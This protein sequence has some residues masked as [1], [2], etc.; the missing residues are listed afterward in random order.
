[1]IRE[2]RRILYP[3]ACLLALSA[4]SVVLAQTVSL[5][6][7]KASTSTG[8]G[9]IT[10][11]A[12]PA[13][14]TGAINLCSTSCTAY[15][16]SNDTVT[17][18]AT[19]D[20]NSTF[21]NWGGDCSGSASGSVLLDA[22]S[23]TCTATFTA[24]SSSVF[25]VTIAK[26]GTGTGTVSETGGKIN[27]GTTCSS[28]YNS[29]SV[30][31]FTASPDANSTFAGWGQNCSTAAT[32]STASL[33]VDAAKTCSAT[34]NTAIQRLTVT[35]TG[36]GSGTVVSS[37][38]G[39]NC[40]SVCT[41]DYASSTTVNLTAT[42]D[43]GM[44]FTG[45][46][47]ACS[48]TAATTKIVLQNPLTCTAN[49]NI[50]PTPPP[51]A[52]LFNITKSGTGKGTVTTSPGSIN[53]GDVCSQEY[54]QNS[55]IV[56]S[57]TPDENS[58]FAGWGAQCSGGGSTSTTVLLNT[59]KTCEVKFSAL[60]ANVWRLQVN[61]SGKGKGT[62]TSMDDQINCGNSCAAEYTS[63]LTM[64][65]TATPDAN[66]SFTGWNSE[67]GE[68][69][70]TTTITTGPS[71]KTCTATFGL[72]STLPKLTI[73]KAGQG[74]G[75]VT[76]TD[77][78]LQCG[79]VCEA[80]Y[81]AGQ[82][83]T[84]IASPDASS[85]FTGW[86][87]EC[88]GNTSAG[89]ITLGDA[90]TT[91]TA[92]FAPK[93]LPQL[94]INKAGQGGGTVTS[95]EGQLQC[96][97][98]CA[99]NYMA[100]NTVTLMASPDANSLFAG[101]GPE[102]D[103]SNGTSATTVT[104]GEADTTCTVNFTPKPPC[105]LQI[106][107]W[108][109]TVS[110][111]VEVIGNSRKMDQYVG[112]WGQD[113]GLVNLNGVSF[114]GVNSVEF[115]TQNQQCYNG[116][117]LNYSYSSCFFKTIFTPITEGQKQ[118]ALNFNFD[119]PTT[120][121]PTVPIQAEAVATGLPK[122]EV[123][124]SSHDFGE[125]TA[126]AL[127]YYQYQR[128]TM[129]NTGNINLSV[130]QLDLTGPNASDFQGHQWSWCSYKGA[131][132]PG[133]ECD[134]YLYFV[135]VEEGD[136]Q[137]NLGVTSNAPAVAVALQ[138][139]ATKPKD[140]E[141]TNITLESVKSGPWATQ[142]GGNYWNY[143]GDSDV[144]QRVNNSTGANYP[145]E[146]DVVRIKSGHTVTA[147]PYAI[148]RTL[149]IE[150]G[151]TL[152]SSNSS[153]YYYGNYVSI[154]AIDYLEN[155]GLIRGKPGANESAGATTCQYSWWG[156]NSCGKPGA[157]VYLSAG[158]FKN[159]GEIVSGQGGSG[160]EYGAWGG[161]ISIYG[162]GLTNTGSGL[163]RAGD[164]GDLTGTQPGQS[165]GGGTIGIWGS[166]YLKSD[167]SRG[168]Y[169]GNGGDCNYAAGQTGGNGGNMRLNAMANVNLQGPFTMGKGGKNCATNGRDGGFN[170]DPN[171][172]T[173]S[174]ANTKVEGGDLTIYGGDG[175]TL[176]LSDLEGTVFT[177]TGN[178][179]LAVGEGGAI[180]MRGS[181][182]D[183]LK[184]SGDVYIFSNTVLLDDQVKL[185]DLIEATNIVVGPAKI[186]HDVS[187][188][189]PGG[190]FGEPQT[191]LPLT[192]SLANGSPAEDT[193]TLTVTD[194]A[195]WPLT[196]LPPTTVTLA[197]LDTIDLSL[198]V[199]LPATRGATNLIKVTATSQADP[200]A[201]ASIEVPVIVAE[202]MTFAP[203][204]PVTTGGT[205][206]P[207]SDVVTPT[208]PTT[209]AESSTSSGTIGSATPAT[210]TPSGTGTGT[211]SQ[212]PIIPPVPNNMI[213]E[214]PTEGV[215]EGMCNNRGR[216]ITGAT[217]TPSAK[218]SGGQ[219]A[220]TIANAGFVS[221]VTIQKTAILKGGT[222]SG[223]IINEGTLEDIKFVG[224]SVTGGTLAGNIINAS[225]VGG[226]FIDVN[227]APNASLRGG[228]LQG[229]IQGDETAPALLEN[230]RVL[231]GSQLT[232]VI[233]G[234]GVILEEGVTVNAV[235]PTT[236]EPPT[237][238]ITPVET[239]PKLPKLAKVTALD[240]EG[241]RITTKTHFAGGIAVNEGTKYET[242][243]KV[244]T[245]VDQLDIRGQMTVE[246]TAVNQTADLFVYASYRLT[247][248]DK[249]IYF[250]LDHNGALLSWDFNNANLVAFK[251]AIKLAEIQPITIYQGTLSAAGYVS[252]HFGYRLADG[253]IVL[254]DDAMTVTISE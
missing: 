128:F 72:L 112:V 81:S 25:T 225:K 238:E 184:A 88:G 119:K 104:L 114:T 49:F 252:I 63:G 190:L 39:I 127:N 78:I 226:V 150:A 169:S 171:V 118:A 120:T 4:P 164:G 236:T 151:G 154:T 15:F 42:A 16:T 107:T 69:L 185:S 210:T 30:V 157:G 12:T 194:S 254:N 206:T 146:K 202:Q 46:S 199:T 173:L 230:V 130:N 134:V 100:G 17:L 248:K 220:G 83:V 29:G 10:A 96:G 34:F 198:T 227:F 214:C 253:S 200:T 87:P 160:Q 140:C 53:C 205:T 235:E 158:I 86:G 62:V 67:C 239:L 221:Q 40:G 145:S 203:I 11:G 172:L 193:F 84:L 168:I 85:S 174:G 183:I 123:S 117:W 136:K 246:Q 23:Q 125:T 77:G 189:N 105:Q 139:K 93:P 167:S 178:I 18:I 7:T 98:V 197:A 111:G 58:S 47:G 44:T 71:S 131:L 113:C 68:T 237:A 27:C 240:A 70:P 162:N 177:A 56:V 66:S 180:D 13:P 31:T 250:M 80:N 143:Q 224:A 79:D 50:I 216:V 161:S 241:Q 35:K 218:L 43:S 89:T 129:K 20:A 82:T 142:T 242:N 217:L 91:C 121:A 48:G 76:S 187:L 110:F 14:T 153:A 182:G 141:D 74:D 8:N 244:K 90:D 147:A 115:S 245:Q 19:P 247:Q 122:I 231:A 37:P 228:K 137:A 103:N 138:G 33:T 108:P 2:I 99:A 133:E 223:Y 75:S 94:I 156:N 144:W 186:L 102:C 9:T 51:P 22:A 26:A 64:S 208:T 215:I 201:S 55:L 176:N 249:A 28:N 54:S 21:T 170:T 251:K 59:A 207:D 97:D 101:W 38:S 195:G 45:W 243:Q 41:A 191:E 5:T 175:W 159:A 60:P 126:G 212:V 109:S 73:N 211:T 229:R 57:A 52:T 219:L 209:G 65:L 95:A 181:S 234:Q 124:P 148:V 152:E 204:T 165:G 32:N 166:N 149:C 213:G 196:K 106:W 24:N 92:N 36:K 163:I 188:S 3:G 233:L 1:M 155:K 6:A 232:G 116:S 135:P 61:K 192:T 179:T 222:L 132:N